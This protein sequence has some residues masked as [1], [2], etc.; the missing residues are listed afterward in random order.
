VNYVQVGMYSSTDATCNGSSTTQFLPSPFCT[1]IGLNQ[2]AAGQ[3]N[4]N[5][6]FTGG[7]CTDANC[8]SCVGATLPSG[9]CVQSPSG[10][11]TKSVCPVMTITP[12]PS[13]SVTVRLFSPTDTTCANV[14]TS[15]VQFLPDPFCIPV[16]NG[17][18]ASGAC[19]PNGTFT[20]GLCTNANCTAC[21]GATVPSGF[22][23]QTPTGA[24]STSTC[25]AVAT[26]TKTPAGNVTTPSKVPTSNMTTPVNGSRTPSNT[27]SVPRTIAT[28]A[29]TLSV[30]VA[31]VVVA[32]ISVLA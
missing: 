26:P 5:G 19:N 16:G 6:T 18:Y 14:N 25:R 4:P 13:N 9:T 23:A 31:L 8:L 32:V 7:V 17:T 28:A 30:S 10:N 21:A 11:F 12:S 27:T 29:T 15:T 20:G 1:Q 24:Y 3:C 22:C 2:Y